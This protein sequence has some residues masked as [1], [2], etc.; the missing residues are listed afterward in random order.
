MQVIL[1]DLEV[2]ACDLCMFTYTLPTARIAETKRVPKYLQQMSVLSRDGK[3][4]VD[5]TYVDNVV[6]GHIL[7]AQ[8]L[9]KDSPVCGK[10]R[11]LWD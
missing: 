1:S 2:C 11:V 5:F 4:L 7:A 10:V 8:K 6:H 3:N 9:G